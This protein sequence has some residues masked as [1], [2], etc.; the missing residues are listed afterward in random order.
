MMDIMQAIDARHSVRAYTDKSI[1]KD[2]LERLKEEVEIC[3]KEAGLNIQIISDEPAAFD[4][5]MAHYGK[6]SGVKNYIALVGK[7]SDD[8]SEKCGYYGERL[9]LL[10]QTLGLNSC[11]V[12]LTFSKKKAKIK[13]D[14]G[15]KLVCV[16]S[17]GY[18]ESQGKQHVDHPIDKI[19]D[20]NADSPQWFKDG[21]TAAMKAPTAMNQQ[22]FSFKLING[23]KVN[24]VSKGGPYSDVDLGIV[25]YH[26]EIGA[27]K[28]NFEFV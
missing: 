13:I 15:E 2:A 5:F 19:A 3:N 14:K 1:G 4:S 12:A 22:K 8:L 25:K 16:I 24:A 6:F 27:G 17:L 11:W 21:I 20:L 18:G 7:K 23:N 28:D 10:A 9:V 26:F